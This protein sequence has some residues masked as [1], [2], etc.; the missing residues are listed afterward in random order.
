[1]RANFGYSRAA[2]RG[3][4]TN[5]ILSPVQDFAMDPKTI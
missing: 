1:M 2:L 3:K 5:V 4:V